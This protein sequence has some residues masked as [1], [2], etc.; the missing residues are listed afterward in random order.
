ML[1]PWGH[2]RIYKYYPQPSLQTSEFRCSGKSINTKKEKS[3]GSVHGNKISK[4]SDIN[5]QNPSNMPE[6]MLWSGT[7]SYMYQTLGDSL[8]GGNASHYTESRWY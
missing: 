5:K 6:S 4:D 2:V 8:P 3:K 7:K 1:N